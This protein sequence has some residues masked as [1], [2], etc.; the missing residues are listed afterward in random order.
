MCKMD[1]STVEMRKSWNVH[2]VEE[3]G[4]CFRCLGLIVAM[5]QKPKP[6]QV[7]DIDLSLRRCLLQN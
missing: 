3:D 1:C 2:L 7:F 6:F 4:A 5:F